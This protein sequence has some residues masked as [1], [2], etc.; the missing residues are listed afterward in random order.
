V[1]EEPEKKE[2]SQSERG[3]QRECRRTS[4]PSSFPSAPYRKHSRV[5]STH[6][7]LPLRGFLKRVVEDSFERGDFVSEGDAADRL[8]SLVSLIG[9]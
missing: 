9:E 4:E 6:L 2:V 1:R 5:P 3:E 8:L 7:A